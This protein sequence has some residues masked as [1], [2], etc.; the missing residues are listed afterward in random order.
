M[1]A[2]VRVI[3]ADDHKIFREGLRV[4][5]ESLGDIEILGEAEN[6]RLLL[7]L[8]RKDEPDLVIVDVAMPDMNGIEAARQIKSFNPDIKVLALSM[9]SDSRF[10]T[11]M[12][13]AGANGYLLK[14]CAFD[15]LTV[16]MNTVSKNQVYLSPGITDLVVKAYL[17][18]NAEPGETTDTGVLTSREREILQLLAEGK[19]TQE[20]A[21][22]L[23]ISSK[24]VD[25]HRRQVMTKLDLHSVAELTQYAIRKGIIVL[26]DM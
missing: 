10:V 15:E 20:I 4:L 2:K 26:D 6:G 23:S 22:A 18:K 19:S 21:T 24:T 7:K 11:Q 14:D 16:A 9:H 3:I 17:T 13:K 12:L 8:I 25:T 5:L 1:T